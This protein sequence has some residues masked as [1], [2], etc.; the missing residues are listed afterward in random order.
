MNA[1]RV[2]GGSAPGEAGRKYL[3]CHR[4]VAAISQDAASLNSG[5]LAALNTGLSTCRS[6]AASSGEGGQ[7]RHVQDR[8]PSPA[9]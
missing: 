3:V 7:A 8:R 1:R 4:Y 2:N 5:S 6:V 9:A